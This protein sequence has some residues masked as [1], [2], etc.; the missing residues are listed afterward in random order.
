MVHHLR[1]ESENPGGKNVLTDKYLTSLIE[2]ANKPDEDL[3]VQ[4][5][6]DTLQESVMEEEGVTEVDPSGSTSNNSTKKALFKQY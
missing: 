2:E 3:N 6:P 1:K 5:E 4:S